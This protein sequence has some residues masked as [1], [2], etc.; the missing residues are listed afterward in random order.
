MTILQL[1]ETIVCSIT[2]KDGDTLTSP[3][4]SMKIVVDRIYP[5]FNNVVSST[6]MV[7][8]STGTYHYDYQ[9]SGDDTGG[10]LVTYTAIDGTK[11]SIEKDTFELE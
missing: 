2:V 5:A 9:S 1:G 4:T 6:A 11:I 8:D 7:E 3:A 10:Y